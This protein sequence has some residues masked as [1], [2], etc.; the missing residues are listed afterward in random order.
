MKIRDVINLILNY[1]PQLDSSIT[2]DGY[3]CGNENEEI[4]GIVTTCCASV[5]V[6]KKAITLG[7]NLIICHEP[8]FYSHYDPT[9]WLKGKNDVFDEKMKLCNDHKITIWRDHD[10][11]HAHRPDGIS[12]GVMKELGWEDYLI[13]N[14]DRPC[15]FHIPP[16][17]VRNLALMLKEKISLNGVRVVGNLDVEVTNIMMYAH[18]LAQGDDFIPTELLNRDDVDV[19]IPGEMVDWTTASYARN[20]GQLGKK[21]AIINVGHFSSEELGMKYAATWI[22]NLIDHCVPVTFVPSADLYQFL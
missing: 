1:H 22:G 20:A 7:A 9:D 3:R 2:C 11:I 21:K 18:I 16:T 17:S 14:T 13:G 8:V 15:H 10:H 19:L 4:K 6:I 5:E 12:Q